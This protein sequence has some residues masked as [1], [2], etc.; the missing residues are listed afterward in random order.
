MKPICV[1]VPY[2]YEK[3][4][5]PNAQIKTRTPSVAPAVFLAEFGSSFNK[6]SCEVVR[7]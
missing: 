6:I 5:A 1:L 3:A 2:L 7:F 4:M